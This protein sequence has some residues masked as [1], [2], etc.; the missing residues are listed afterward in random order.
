MPASVAHHPIFTHGRL[1]VQVLGDR[2][3]FVGLLL[4]ERLSA[5]DGV[6]PG[7]TVGR[8]CVSAGVYIGQGQATTL[9]TTTAYQVNALGLGGLVQ[10]VRPEPRAEGHRGGGDGQERVELV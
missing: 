7:W 9:S 2:D 3:A 10:P 1:L 4:G 8:R 6:D 5:A